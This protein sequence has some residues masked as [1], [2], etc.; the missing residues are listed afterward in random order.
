MKTFIA[1]LFVIFSII[2]IA[3]ASFIT[4]EKFAGIIPDCG[5]GF[6]CGAVL[7]SKWSSI[8]P[9]PLSLLGLFYYITVF[10]LGI[11][12]VLEIEIKKP[13]N[14]F[15]DKIRLSQKNIL[16]T[17]NTAEALFLVTTFGF[18]FSIY[19]VVLMAFVIEAWCKYCV[20]SAA[21]STLLFITSNIYFS[22]IEKR[23][24][25][26]P[27][28]LTFNFLHWG[29]TTIIKRLFFLMDAEDAHNSCTHFGTVLGKFSLTQWVTKVL[30]S[31]TNQSSAKKLNGILF[32]NPVGLAAGF[33]YN[34]QLTSIL[35]DLGMGFHTIGTV[36]YRPY[37]GNKKPRLGRFLESKSLLVNKGLKSL[38]A[39]IIAKNL[40]GIKFRIPTGISIAST[41]TSFRNEA[42]QILDIL[43]TFTIF[44]NSK[45]QHSYYELNIS[46][47][48]T[49][50]GEPFT[51]PQRL[52]ILL[53]AIEKL[54]IKKPI[55]VKMP[56]DQSKKETLELLTVIYK[57]TIAGVIFGNLTKDKNNPDVTE[58]DRKKW[59]TV[60]GNLSGKPTWKR[61]NDLI[62]LTRRNFGKRFTIIGT[63]GIFSGSDAQIKIDCG[64]D[65]IQL[66]TGMIFE[67]PQVV[68]EINLR[69]AQESQKK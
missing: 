26:I 46:C 31:F 23:S 4:Y 30:F 62:E 25:F 55:F 40:T 69:L 66:I 13:M 7:N 28:L 67:G 24:P 39:V 51:T 14:R 33:D 35:P 9:V 43:K 1:L 18:G 53:S 45:V 54:Q 37:E 2:G 41:N 34:G 44:E 60:K 48:N 5:P 20:I 22:K 19:L 68:G 57:F 17:I 21:S 49:F 10:A 50:G 63:G 64:A 12:L 16:R 42:E 8:G 61:S 36:T 11:L 38:G 6:D 59:L 3:D 27:K 29:Y 52:K 65:L 15:F 47:P 32:P 56:I 58:T